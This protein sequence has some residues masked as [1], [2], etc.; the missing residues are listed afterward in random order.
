M[1]HQL[2]KLIISL[3]KE[4][5]RNFKLYSSRFR[6]KG[7]DKKMIRL[8]DYI[9]SGQYDEY[10]LT[11][12][13]LLF[14][15]A[16]KNAYYQ[17]KN[18][19]IKEIEESLLL[20]HKPQN[21]EYSI[22]KLLQLVNVFSSKA[23]YDKSL[24]YLQ[25][26]EKLA[27]KTNNTLV[28]NVIYDKWMDD[29]GS[30]MSE[31]EIQGF[32][33][34]SLGNLENSLTEF[35]YKVLVSSLRTKLSKANFSSK[36]TQTIAEILDETIRTLK[37]EN[38]A[39]SST[40]LRLRLNESIRN[41]LLIRKQYKELSEY[42]IEDFSRFENESIFESQIEE[43]IKQLTW[44]INVLLRLKRVAEMNIYI[45]QLEK[46]LD[47][48]ENSRLSERYKWLFAQCKLISFTYNNQLGNA[49]E[50]LESLVPEKDK[51]P[52][53]P[54]FVNLNLAVLHY[55]NKNIEISLDYLAKIILD[56]SF[57]KIST[58]LQL[59]VL[60][61]E[62]VLRVENGDHFYA[63]NKYGS[64]RRKYRNHL[65]NKDY[66][67]DKDFLDLLRDLIKDKQKERVNPVLLQKI[68][69]FI[70]ASPPFE[71]GS[72]EVICYHLWLEAHMRKITYFER[73]LQEIKC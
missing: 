36:S 39:L 4:E 58:P 46:V 14:S 60:I 71:P 64:L 54:I 48:P 45:S 29:I 43:K 72:N 42:L 51:V 7:E 62:L 27:N 12:T 26:A 56:D 57:G 68:K 20:L 25:K 63:K 2:T 37:I 65:T 70:E 61:V 17:L 47:A 52:H 30:M 11:L 6:Y 3:S 44:I 53:F 55:Y 59:T 13:E 67:R 24:F 22:Y 35:K 32:E 31:T 73:V 19:L 28:L 21:E 49:I 69:G 66:K 1:K 41:V 40:K 18:R 50:L 38:K 10:D 5:I 23:E 8:F 15:N 9:K 16:S 34:K 33:M